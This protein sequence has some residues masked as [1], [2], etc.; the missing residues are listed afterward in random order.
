M[1]RLDDKIA[2]VTGAGRGIGR[3]MAVRLAQEGAYV[4]VADI[5]RRLAEETAA[6]VDGAWTQESGPAGRCLTP[7]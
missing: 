5:D 6:Q 7:G 2:L 1:A 3:A 4:V